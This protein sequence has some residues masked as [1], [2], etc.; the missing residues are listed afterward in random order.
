MFNRLASSLKNSSARR[1]LAAGAFAGASALSV[2]SIAFADPDYKQVRIAIDEI[3]DGDQ[4]MGPTLVR[5]AWHAS[6]TYSKYEN[7]GG[8]DGA[9]MRFNPEASWGAN[10]G[11]SKARDALEPVKQRFPDISYADLWTL[12]GVAAIEY[13]GGPEIQWRPGR[14]DKPD[15]K[16]TVPDGR[17]PDA[18]QGPQHI[19]DIFYRMGFDDREIVALVGAHCLGRCHRENS[20]YEGP[21]TRAPT[22][23]SNLYFKELLENKWTQKQWSGPFQYEDPSKE[24]MMLPGD[25]A[26]VEDPSF[27]KYVELYA[28]DENAFF[29][30]FASAFQKLEEAGVKKFTKTG[31]FF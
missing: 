29:K 24:L 15:G 13:M 31:W 19:R 5:L 30:D 20:G 1:V 22:T 11:L 18:S 2:S 28:K 3:L 23:F 7:N 21:W 6:G 16:E 27:K 12:A 25:M 10:K 8:S 14:T 17:L 4:N 26:L 9:T